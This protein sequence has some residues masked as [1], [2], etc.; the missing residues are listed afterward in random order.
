VP[1]G[2]RLLVPPRTQAA[3]L[4]RGGGNGSNGS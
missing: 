2:T 3:E 1:V 4:S